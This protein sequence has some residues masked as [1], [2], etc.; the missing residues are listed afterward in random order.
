[1]FESLFVHATAETRDDLLF[2]VK[3]DSKN[4]SYLRPGNVCI[5]DLHVVLHARLHHPTP[6]GTDL[7]PM[8]I[9][10]SGSRVT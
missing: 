5:C 6:A 1:M 9:Y 2:Y 7:V 8:V 10:R 3:Y 4:V